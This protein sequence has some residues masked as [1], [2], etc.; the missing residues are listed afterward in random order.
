M[1]KVRCPIC[2]KEMPGQ[3]GEWPEHPSCSKRCRTID[4]GRW[5]GE[6]YR[7]PASSDSDAAAPPADDD[8]GRVS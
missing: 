3:P 7:F 4:L 8:P 5:L 1:K 2:D 6:K